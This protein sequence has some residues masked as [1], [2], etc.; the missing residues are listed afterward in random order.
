M[1]EFF[2]QLTK[3]GYEVRPARFEDLPQLV[4]MFNAAEAELSGAGCCQK[5]RSDKSCGSF[6]RVHGQ[7]LP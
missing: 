7:F 5:Q 6:V 3:A 2:G 4:P 1:D